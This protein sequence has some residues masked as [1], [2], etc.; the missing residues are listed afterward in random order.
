MV[1]EVERT[2]VIGAGTMGHGIA[3]VFAMNGLHVNLVDISEEIL[4]KAIDRIKW[5]LG[6]LAQK[7][8][9]REEDVEATLSR[10]RTT[11]NIA[12]AVRDVDFVV[13]AVPEDIDIKRQVFSEVDKNAPAH[14]VIATNTSGLPI[15]AMAEATR[16]PEKVLGMHW[17]NPPVIMRLVEVI[18]SKSTSEEAAQLTYE[19]ARR[20]G[21]EAIIVAKDIRGFLANRVYWAV[22]Y[23]AF[24][25][26]LRGEARP[27]EV[28]AAFRYRLNIPMGPF[29]LTDFTGGVE[30]EL[31]ADRSLETLRRQYPE[32][33]PHE[34]YVRFRAFALRLSRQ[35]YER[36]W[37]GVKTGKGFYTYPE[38]GKWKK[39]EIP[40]E[41]AEKVEPI[42]VVA[43]AINLAAWLIGRG[44]VRPEDV[45]TALEL[46]FNWPKG[47]MKLAEEWGYGE[48][49]RVLREKREKYAEEPYSS[50]YEPE[51][52]L[53]E[54]A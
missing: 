3:Q 6:K 14:A 43:P 34:E 2:A 41:L 30:I 12:E 7:G 9:I 47:P 39:V 21:K 50:F 29:E 46:G 4:R 18:R 48:V 45:D 28:D 23:E 31:L 19:L 37:L 24:A 25:M 20:V 32:W 8:K 44:Y 42:Q 54:R 16:R 10:I 53:I 17:F 52:Y 38:P 49:V 36:G 27:E 26:F 5:S 1:A 33:E 40:E 11:T 35:Y 51:P 22:R 15:I 13:E